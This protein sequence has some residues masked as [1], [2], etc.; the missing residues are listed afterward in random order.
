MAVIPVDIAGRPYEVRVGAGLL[1]EL[2]EHCRGR[3][4][5]RH[6]PVITDANVHRAWGEV[7]ET[8]LRGS[9]H[10]PHWRIL[11]AGETTKS[12]EELAATVNWLLSFALRYAPML[13]PG[14][15]RELV[16]EAWVADNEAFQSATGWLPAIRL[17]EG[18]AQLFDAS[19]RD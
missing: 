17:A 11:P 8:A 6:V 3:L 7:V 15:A 10:E 12:W 5:K 18:A 2:V 19:M 4:R 14:K 9:G 16:Q 13:T 1:A